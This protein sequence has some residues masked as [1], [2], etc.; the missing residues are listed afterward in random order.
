MPANT[1]RWQCRWKLQPAPAMTGGGQQPEGAIAE[2]HDAVLSLI[3]I[4]R[5]PHAHG[6]RDRIL[7]GVALVFEV[8]PDNEAVPRIRIHDLAHLSIRAGMLAR[9]SAAAAADRPR[10]TSGIGGPGR[11]SRHRPSRSCSAPRDNARPAP[12]AH[13]LH[14]VAQIARALDEDCPGRHPQP[15]FLF[16][17]RGT[18]VRVAG[19]LAV[20][21]EEPGPG[22]A[23]VHHPRWPA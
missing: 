21:L 9:F 3:Q 6:L 16:L 15:E 23:R 2:A 12:A 14:R 10:A 1:S 17:V 18:G 20:A 22:L 19:L 13:G 7:Q 4:L 8:V 11:S 5:A